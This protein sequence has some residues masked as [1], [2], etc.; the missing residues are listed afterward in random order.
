MVRVL[1]VP[2]L[3][4]PAVPQPTSLGLLGGLQAP[5]RLLAALRPRDAP[6]SLAGPDG[7]LTRGLLALPVS[8]WPCP[9]PPLLGPARCRRFLEM[10]MTT[11]ALSV[12]DVGCG[13]GAIGLALLNKLPEA[14]CVA[15]DISGP[16]FLFAVRPEPP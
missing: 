9:M 10:P 15:I 4:P 16:G 2:S 3:R 5:A 6:L 8:A 12:L 13:S 1:R 11:Q 7:R 14:R